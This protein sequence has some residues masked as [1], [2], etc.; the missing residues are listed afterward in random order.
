MNRMKATQWLK[1]AEHAR[2]IA[3]A[4]Q[5]ATGKKAMLE[6]AVR[7]EIIA[8]LDKAKRSLG[9]RDRTLASVV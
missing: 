8:S 1:L 9:L 7:Y 6:I 5:D 4:M 3:H 2:S